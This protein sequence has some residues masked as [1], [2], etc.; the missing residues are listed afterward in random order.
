[1]VEQTHTVL[2]C[3]GPFAIHGPPVIEACL[4]SGTHYVDITGTG[5]RAGTHDAVRREA[6]LTRGPVARSGGHPVQAR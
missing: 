6:G 3:A 1:M 5:V 4:A 2:N